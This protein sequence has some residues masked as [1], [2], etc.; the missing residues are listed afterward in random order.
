MLTTSGPGNQARAAE[1]RGNGNMSKAW[2]DARHRQKMLRASGAMLI[3][4]GI[5]TSQQQSSTRSCCRVAS[6]IV[7]IATM[8]KRTACLLRWL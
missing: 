3:Q 4:G 1:P 6:T 7:T 5:M 2:S 8:R